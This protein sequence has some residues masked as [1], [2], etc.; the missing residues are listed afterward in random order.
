MIRTVIDTNVLAS[1]L[2]SEAGTPGRILSCWAVGLFDLVLSEYILA[3]LERTLAKPYFRRSTSPDWA[4]QQLT[5]LQISGIVVPISVQVSGVAAHSED[6]LVLAT[7]VSGRARY[8][9]TGDKAMQAI[10][11]YLGVNVVRPL[12]FLNMLMGGESGLSSPA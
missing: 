8:L 12:D 10:G 9:V 7:A 2:I 4:E 1:G 11:L 3:E 5:W 6:D